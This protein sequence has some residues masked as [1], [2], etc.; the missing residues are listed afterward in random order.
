MQ[1][2]TTYNNLKS[3][4][5]AGA[6]PQRSIDEMRRIVESDIIQVQRLKRTLRSWRLDDTELQAIEAEAAR[7]H[8]QSQKVLDA[9]RAG[10]T[11]DSP[12]E[13]DWAEV[14]IRSPIDGEILELN[15]AVGDIVTSTDDLFKIADLSRLIVMANA[16]EE[17]LPALKRLRTIKRVGSS[18]WSLN[19]P[20]QSTP[21]KS[22]RLAAS[23]IQPAYGR[24]SRLDR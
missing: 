21:A 11:S 22:V 8:N 13:R 3:V 14:D 15:L 1:H 20:P 23:S 4:E 19:L 12:I 6:V 17:D 7:V 2:E 24:C 10:T 9:S 5:K 16:Y 18:S